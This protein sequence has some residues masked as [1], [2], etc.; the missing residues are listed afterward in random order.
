VRPI[1][2]GGQSPMSLADA[3][4]ERRMSTTVLRFAGFFAAWLTLGKNGPVDLL[5][6]LGAALA[7]A[8]A[9]L[10]LLPPGAWRLRP[11]P[12]LRLAA[13]FL[14]QSIVGGADVAWR[15]L[16]PRMPLRVGTVAY[17]VRLPAGLPR[18]AFNTLA[19][20]VPGTLPCGPNEDG[21][22]VIHCLDVDE[23]VLQ[24]MRAEEELLG[25]ALGLELRR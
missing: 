18:N 16:A 17:P 25:E 24:Q 19:S 10:R 7:A 20:V 8:W 13:R 22:C 23:P 11:L 2:A 14:R 12:L 6:G 5:V 9:S 15:A 21:A 1:P 3:K 4:E